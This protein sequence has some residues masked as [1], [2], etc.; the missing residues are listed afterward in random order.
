MTNETEGRAVFMLKD[1]GEVAGA[2][3]LIADSENTVA[4]G[5]DMNEA[6]YTVA[7]AVVD[8]LGG[9]EKAHDGIA[10]ATM[11]LQRVTRAMET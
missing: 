9:P 11:F 8:L 1:A 7:A 2:I 4:S 10:A 3:A 5:T 6:V